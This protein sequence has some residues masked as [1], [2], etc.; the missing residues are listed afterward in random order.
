[1]IDVLR[2]QNQIW[3]ID[4][5]YAGDSFVTVISCYAPTMIN[6]D[7]VKETFYEDLNSLCR[8]V[9]RKDKLIILGE[10]NARVG[11]D[12]ITWPRVLGHHG[13]EK[14]NSNGLLLFTL[15][16][17]STS[18]LLQI[19]SFNKPINSR[20]HGCI[21]DPNSGT[22]WT[23]SLFATVIIKMCTLQD[24]WEELNASQTTE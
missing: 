10:F 22:C 4:S 12:L 20:T 8:T 2:K 14:C 13:T 7:T 15:C 3:L 6:T 23:K 24:A 21:P 9:D 19:L 16:Y 17:L 11:K 1:M 5:A 18:W